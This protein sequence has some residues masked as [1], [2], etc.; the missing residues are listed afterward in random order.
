MVTAFGLIG[1]PNEG[2]IVLSILF[3]FVGLGASLPGGLVWLLSRERRQGA[4][5]NVIEAELAVKQNAQL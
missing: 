3:G 4:A 2:A 5:L 1:V